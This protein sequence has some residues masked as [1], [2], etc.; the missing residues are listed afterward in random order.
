MDSLFCQE[1]PNAMDDVIS[2]TAIRFGNGTWD[3]LSRK[4]AFICMCFFSRPTLCGSMRARMLK[5]PWSKCPVFALALFEFFSTMA[6]FTS[7]ERVHAPPEFIFH[8][9][10]EIEIESFV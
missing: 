1:W 6:G 2:T 7:L 10:F 8:G 4:G 3:V 5:V 9:I